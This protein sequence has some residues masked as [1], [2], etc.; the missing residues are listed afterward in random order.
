MGERQRRDRDREREKEREIERECVYSGYEEVDLFSEIRGKP[1]PDFD[2]VF[3]KSGAPFSSAVQSS[4]SNLAM[5]GDLLTPEAVGEHAKLQQEPSQ[6]LT[7][8]TSD[9]E[10]SLALA[11]EN[12]S[13]F[14]FLSLGG[15]MCYEMLFMQYFCRSQLREQNRNGEKVSLQFFV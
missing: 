15:K 14:H 13:T 12:L 10:S 6:S 8:L 1:Q 5:G 4:P 11:A 2:S 7:G 3:G 9:V